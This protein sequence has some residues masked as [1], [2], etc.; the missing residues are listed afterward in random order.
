LSVEAN[1]AKVLSESK[2]AA[3]LV[4]ESLKIEIDDLKRKALAAQAQA[5]APVLVAPDKVGAVF[6][7]FIQKCDN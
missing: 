1:N 5:S 7:Q 3:D 2:I 6:H 4:V